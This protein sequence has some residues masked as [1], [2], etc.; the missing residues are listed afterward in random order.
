M[1]VSYDWVNKRQHL[2][3]K[4]SKSIDW[5]SLPDGV[6]GHRSLLGEAC[7]LRKLGYRSNA[8]VIS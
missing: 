3:S 2:A 8:S 7:N 1:Q 6:T 4:D 5:A